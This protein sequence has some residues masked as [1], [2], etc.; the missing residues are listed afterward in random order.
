MTSLFHCTGKT[1]TAISQLN[2]CLLTLVLLSY[3]TLKSLAL[4]SPCHP[5]RYWQGAGRVPTNHLCYRV[6]KPKS[7]FPSSQCKHSSYCPS[8]ALLK[9]VL[10]SRVIIQSSPDAV[11]PFAARVTAGSCSVCC[12]SSLW[13]FATDQTQPGSPSLPCNQEFSISRCMILLLSFLNYIRL[14]LNHYP[15]F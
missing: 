2:L 13:A 8:W 9:T 12:P 4:F 6:N 3:T 7:L 5:C 14:P 1:P 10:K 11:G 15:S